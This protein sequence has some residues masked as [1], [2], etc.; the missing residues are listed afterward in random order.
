MIERLTHEDFDSKSLGLVIQKSWPESIMVNSHALEGPNV[1]ALLTFCPLY[2][3]GALKDSTLMTPPTLIEGSRVANKWLALQAVL[4]TM[5]GYL[6][7]VGGGLDVQAVF[8]DKAVLLAHDPTDLDHLALRHHS[9]IYREV[10]N[11]YCN[12]QDIHYTYATYTDLHVPGPVF[13]NPKAPIHRLASDEDTMSLESRLI[14]DLN[15]F[16]RKEEIPSQVIDNRKIRKLMQKL[17]SLG[18]GTSSEEVYWLV[19]GYLAFDHIISNLVS[20]N[21]LY[22]ATERFEPLFGISNMTPSLH[23]MPRIHI[24]A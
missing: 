18:G 20:P 24:K 13:V 22:I 16:L 2:K 8:A 1:K 17:H 10:M 6:K 9:N 23:A 14:A 19:T 21:G 3:P 7:S 12:E 4:T 11:Q 5:Q 15:T